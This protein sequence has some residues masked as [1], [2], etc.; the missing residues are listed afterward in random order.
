MRQANLYESA[1]DRHTF[2]ELTTLK[3][4]W[5]PFPDINSWEL[6]LEGDED[7][8]VMLGTKFQISGRRGW[9]DARDYARGSKPARDDGDW[10]EVDMF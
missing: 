4:V 7:L 2:D 3:A 6:Y 10:E 1:I 5:V 9:V 8:P